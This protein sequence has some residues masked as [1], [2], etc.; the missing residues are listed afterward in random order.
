[1]PTTLERPPKESPGILNQVDQK[2][3]EHFTEIIKDVTTDLDNY[4]FH[5][6]SDKLYH[7]VWDEFAAKILEDSK[8]IFLSEDLPRQTGN[9]AKISRQQFLIDTLEKILITLHPFMPFITEEIWQSLPSNPPDLKGAQG[10]A[11]RG[12]LLIEKWPVN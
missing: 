2:L 5:L 12:L 4:R 6:A 7:Y 11:G 10:L 3:S 9:Q 8:N 1:T